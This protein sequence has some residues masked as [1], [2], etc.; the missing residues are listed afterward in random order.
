MSSDTETNGS[1]KAE[2]EQIYHA[3]YHLIEHAKKSSEGRKAL[4]DW[5][6]LRP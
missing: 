1:L 3:A 6:R 5:D 2:I 4:R